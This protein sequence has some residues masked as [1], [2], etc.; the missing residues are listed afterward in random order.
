LLPLARGWR[1]SGM[2]V[3]LETGGHR[4]QELARLIDEI[5]IVVAD[6]KLASSAGVAADPGIA[7]AFLALAGRKEC[8]VKLV[9]N[10]RTTPAEVT[11]AA[12]LVEEHAPAASLILQP[13]SG[14]RFGPPQG[15][16]L[17]VLQRAAIPIHR[18]TRV[19]PQT[20]RQLHLR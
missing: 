15:S 3:L 10:R 20:H 11:R 16:L 12:A 18:A 4:P 1:R 19:I 17:L 14:A 7:G 5:D 9:V 13:V 2:A 6:M 8:T